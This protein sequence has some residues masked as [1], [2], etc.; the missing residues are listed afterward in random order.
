MDLI[1]QCGEKQV[2]LYSGPD[3]ESPH[4]KGRP[5]RFNTIDLP[6]KLFDLLAITV[7]PIVP[8]PGTAGRAFLMIA[9]HK[10]DGKRVD[11]KVLVN[12]S[13]LSVV[14]YPQ[15]LFEQIGAFDIWVET[16]GSKRRYPFTI[17]ELHINDYEE[18]PKPQICKSFSLPEGKPGPCVPSPT[19]VMTFRADFDGI[20]NDNDI[21]PETYRGLNWGNSYLRV[22]NKSNVNSS[23]GGPRI[24]PGTP[25]PVSGDS[26][27]LFE[28][29]FHILSDSI[30]NR[31]G[32]DELSVLCSY[33]QGVDALAGKPCVVSFVG[34]RDPY[35][36]W[37]LPTL[38]E[39][40][41]TISNP[42][43]ANGERRMTKIK[44]K[45]LTKDKLGFQ[46]LVRLDVIA[47]VGD[48]D[49]KGE[50]RFIPV[51]AVVD[52]IWFTQEPGEGEKCRV[53]GD[54]IKVRPIEKVLDLS[55]RV[56]TSYSLTNC[57]R[58]RSFL[59]ATRASDLV[60][61]PCSTGKW[62]RSRHM[63]QERQD[64]FL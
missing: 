36:G 52:D 20:P 10:R 51:S 35:G 6:Y 18:V 15:S 45:D 59:T 17:V 50:R 13:G 7:Y 3:G 22:F 58:I 49:S 57:Q 64:T 62:P 2:V 38:V 61:D 46:K 28:G 55:S 48:Y 16:E 56:L 4:I 37:G 5:M 42:G 19:S 31:F 27:G 63:L 34:R 43:D 41:F 23:E 39:G 9:G 24:E 33:P 25:L 12:P 11:F 8:F 54:I 47:E 44:L 21:I 53:R 60:K 40:S 32:V 30:D 26:F 14:T 1:L 29:E